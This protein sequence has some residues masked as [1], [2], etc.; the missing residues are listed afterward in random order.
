MGR[1][2]GIYY[3]TDRS[4]RTALCSLLS[5]EFRIDLVA[6]YG[7]QKTKE[8]WDIIRNLASTLAETTFSFNLV[9]DGP[10]LSML[11]TRIVTIGQ[12]AIDVRVSARSLRLLQRPQEICETAILRMYEVALELARLISGTTVT[13]ALFKARHNGCIK[14]A[15]QV[16]TPWAEIH[17]VSTEVEAIRKL[18]T[19]ANKSIGVGDAAGKGARSVHP[20]QIGYS[21]H[22]KMHKMQL[23][24]LSKSPTP[25]TWLH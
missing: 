15:T 22:L 24:V 9:K 11:A 17:G 6:H 8:V 3:Q 12:G 2:D 1:I 18:N 16:A 13:E 23:T 20:S 5:N 10:T 4:A 7:P 25:L 21:Q 19:S 14:A